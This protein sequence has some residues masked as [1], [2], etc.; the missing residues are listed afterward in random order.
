MA[1]GKRKQKKHSKIRC[2]RKKVVAETKR[3]NKNK[4]KL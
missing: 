2:K 4:L 3:T 1:I